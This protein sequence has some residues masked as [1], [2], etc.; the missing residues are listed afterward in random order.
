[1]MPGWYDI[2][3]MDI[4]DKQ[5]AE[6]MA[7]SQAMLDSLI[8]KQMSLGIPSENIIIAGFSQGG[9]VAYHTGLRAKHKLAG[10]LALSTYLP[11]AEQAEQAHTK[12]NIDTPILANHGTHDPVV[13]LDLG[14][15]ECGFI[16]ELGLSTGVE[17][18]PYGTPG[19]DRADQRY[20]ELDKYD[21]LLMSASKRR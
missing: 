21:T 15:K 13:P 14:K 8:E 6:G 20:W 17:G 9:A 11:F 5:D 18:I 7:E 10:I 3:G 12:V 1:M 16:D 2:K 4:A 19:R